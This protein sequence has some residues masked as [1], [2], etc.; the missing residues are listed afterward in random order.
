MKT[1]LVRA[2]LLSKSGYGVHSRQLFRYLFEKQQKNNNFILKTQI[3]NWGITPWNINTDNELIKKIIELNV[4]QKE[5]FDLTFQL[6]LPNEWD[7]TLGNYNIGLTAG[8]ETDISNPMWMSYCKKM[9]K[10]I[11]PSEF[12]KNSLIGSNNLNSNV[13]VV[14]EG[15]YDLIEKEMDELNLDLKTNFNF[16]SVGVMTGTSPDNDRKNLFYLVK[17]FIE[18]FKNDPDVGLILKTN[19]GRDSSLDKIGTLNVLKQ[20]LKELGHNGTPK[21][22]LLHGD[23]PENDMCKLYKNKNVKCFVTLTRGEGFGLPLLEAA[24]SNLPI[25]A[26]NWSAH[27]EFLNLGKWIKLDYK[28]EKVDQSKIDNNIFV[29]G[30]RWANVDEQDFKQKIRKFKTSPSMPKQWANELG[31]KIRKNYSWDNIYNQYEKVV[32]ELLC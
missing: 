2:P 29:N 11:V 10:V 5:K 26:T 8:V 12:T 21:I 22:Y 18:E 20:L 23:I 9:D 6:Q 17:W 4:E 27:T 24:A 15:Y 30:A 7:N 25:I 3:L 28:L 1:V 16:L 14:N 13:Y 32:G 31:E 19:R